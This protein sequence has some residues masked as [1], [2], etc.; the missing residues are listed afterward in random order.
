VN[1]DGFA[2]TIIGFF[3]NWC[4]Y[5]AADLAGV[6]RTHYPGTVRIIRVMCSSRVDPHMVVTAFLGGAD[7]VLVAGCHPGDCHYVTGNYRTRRRFAMLESMFNALGLDTERI[8]LAWIAA[9]EG[10]RV[11]QVVSHLT[12]VVK[13]IGPNPTREAMFL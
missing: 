8:K 10:N 3:C 1:P 11:G 13:Q 4:S 2:P 6:S 7:G 5:T 12:D 9:S